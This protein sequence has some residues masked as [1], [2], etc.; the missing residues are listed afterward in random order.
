MAAPTTP[1][2]F[3]GILKDI[4]TLISARNE[5]PGEGKVADNIAR[6]V[7]GLSMELND[8][9]QHHTS[10]EEPSCADHTLLLG[11]H[12]SIEGIPEAES[13]LG[14]ILKDE[15]IARRVL[16]PAPHGCRDFQVHQSL[17]KVWESMQLGNITDKAIRQAVLD[18]F[19][20]HSNPVTPKESA[21][22]RGGGTEESAQGKRGHGSRRSN[23]EQSAHAK[24][25]K[26]N[27]RRSEEEKVGGWSF[28]VATVR[29]P[30]KL[31]WGDCLALVYDASRGYLVAQDV[32]KPKARAGSEVELAISRLTH[33]RHSPSEEHIQLHFDSLDE[34]V[35]DIKMHVDYDGHG[36]IKKIVEAAPKH[37]V[38]K[39][40]KNLVDI[41]DERGPAGS[42]KRESIIESN[43]KILAKKARKS[44]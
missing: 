3:S 36:L 25:E 17:Q 21:R 2:T 34:L 42:K 41:M 30:D 32:D 27:P 13:I 6:M 40:I 8:H 18:T 19:S 11:V 7:E 12:D 10:P 28:P 35:L 16:H 24:P 22:L 31:L 29:F 39:I 43:G 5:L 23:N 38:V 4:E 37:C 9:Y 15:L 1:K 33:L 20:A 14:N 26:T 44:S